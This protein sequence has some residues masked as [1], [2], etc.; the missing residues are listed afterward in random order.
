MNGWI[1][2]WMDERMMNEW[3]VNRWMIGGWING[4]M[5]EWMDKWML[6]HVSPTFITNCDHSC[7]PFHVLLRA[8]L[9]PLRL[10]QKRPGGPRGE[11]GLA[12]PP[13]CL[14]LSSPPQS[15][16]ACMGTLVHGESQGGLAGKRGPHTAL[17]RALSSREQECQALCQGLFLLP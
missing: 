14:L 6:D 4:W 9:E 13:H 7:I 12:V 15:S 8:A 11:A 3:M 17:E 10:D 5:E 16:P 2:G 1:N